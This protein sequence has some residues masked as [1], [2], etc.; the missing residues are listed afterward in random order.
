MKKTVIVTGANSGI[1]REVSRILVE[2][3]YY[4]IMLGR[5]SSRLLE[6]QN[7][8]D[9]MRETTKI[10]SCDLSQLASI[11]QTVNIIRQSQMPIHGL[12]NA[13]GVGYFKNT[14]DSTDEEIAQTF[15]TNALGLIYLTKYV[16]QLMV[17]QGFGHIINVASMAGKLT[18]PKAAV[19]G[20]SK[21][22]V[23]AFSN[24]LRL[25]MRPY[26]VLVS[27]V[28]TGPVETPFLNKADKTGNYSN[29]VQ[30]YLL[31]STA[32]AKKIALLLE[33]YKRE[34]N[35]PWYMEAAAKLYPFAPRVG[36]YLSGVVFNKK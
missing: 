33:R 18:T 14:I 27:T 21:A 34:V 4:V 32:V 5:N 6:V 25:E 12:V 1:G 31:N 24:G 7:S 17:K 8:L 23:I 35:L 10:L 19:Y 13:A 22:A 26:H 36:D 30:N 28:N 9:P 15:Q 2:Q 3:N 29:S 20:S 11:R 16:A